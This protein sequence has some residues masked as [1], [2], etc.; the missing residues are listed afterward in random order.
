MCNACAFLCCASDQ[1]F[2]CGCDNC[3]DEDCWPDDE[4][5]DPE[6]NDIDVRPT[7]HRRLRCDAVSVNA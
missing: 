2:G 4:D 1:F 6:W 5:F 7:H 3:Y